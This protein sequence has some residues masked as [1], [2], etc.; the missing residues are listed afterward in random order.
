MTTPQEKNNFAMYPSLILSGLI[1]FMLCSS[2]FFSILSPMPL[3]HSA[4]RWGKVK[5]QITAALA[6]I[7]AFFLFK[8]KDAGLVLVAMLGFYI[9]IAMMIIEIINRRLA[10]FRSMVLSSTLIV[11]LLGVVGLGFFESKNMSPIEYMT[12]EVVKNEKMFTTQFALIYEK[13]SLEYKEFIRKIEK[14]PKEFVKQIA[15]A[16]PKLIIILV[17]ITFWINLCLGFKTRFLDSERGA[18]LTKLVHVRLPEH[19]IWFFIAGL[20]AVLLEDYVGNTIFEI[21]SYILTVLGIFY[22]FQGFGVYISFLDNVKIE[23]FFRTLLVASTIFW[24]FQVLILIG[25]S[26]LFVNY[27]RFF[28][29]E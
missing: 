5:A 10:P 12:A 25:L 2:G 18:D 16:I 28:K 27:R 22:F 7:V 20:S 14:E 17:F 8:E 4:V 21:G 24:A 26:D 9:A 13:D 19:L 3:V 1:T 11:L 23:G 6:L 29:K 15:P